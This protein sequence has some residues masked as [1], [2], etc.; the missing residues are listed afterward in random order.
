MNDEVVLRHDRPDAS[1]CPVRAK[2][3]IE[4][5]VEL[6]MPVGSFI[7]AVLANDLY[8]AV[9]RAD[10]VNLPALPHIVA[11]VV[12]HVPAAMRGSDAIV[13]AHIAAKRKAVRDSAAGQRRPQLDSRVV[14]QQETFRVTL[15]YAG[16]PEE[17]G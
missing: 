12:W 15:E 5:Y 2:A 13:S 16:H 4:A 1:L 7:R 9:I 11:Y 10:E 6:G 14:D 8:E 17:Q 3:S